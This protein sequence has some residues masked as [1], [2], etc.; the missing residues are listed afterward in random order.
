MVA[1]V[2]TA[3]EQLA[4]RIAAAWTNA[5]LHN[6]VRV[7]GGRRAVGRGRLVS[8]VSGRQ[9]SKVPNGD[10]GVTRPGI[11]A[12]GDGTVVTQAFAAD[13]ALDTAIAASERRAVTAAAIGP[14]T[15]PRNRP[16]AMAWAR[17]TTAASRLAMAA[18]RLPAGPHPVL[19]ER[20]IPVPMPDGVTL[21]ADRYLPASAKHA[22]G[23]GLPPVILVRSPYGRSRF[24][25]LAYGYFFAQHGFQ[26]VVQSVRGTF[27]SGGVFDPL[28]NE[29]GDGLATV[30]WLKT[31][32]WFGGVFAMHGPSYLGYSQWAIAAHAGPELR[33][34]ATQIAASQFYEAAYVG[35]AFALES[36]LSWSDLTSRIERPIGGLTAPVLSVRRAR[37]AAMSGRPLSELDTLAAGEPVP[38][39]QDIL[40]N[41]T[42]DGAYWRL[43][44]HS[45][46]VGRVEAPVSLLGGWYDVFLPWQ[47]QDYA[48]LRRVGRHPRLTIGPWYHVDPRLL[49]AGAEDALA[50]FRAH[51][52]DDPSRLR[53]QPVRLFITGA[54]QWRHYPDWPVPGM[55]QQ[56]WHLH[57][58]HGLGPGRPA[59]SAP[60]AYRFDPADPT[61]AMNGPTLIGN[62]Q[63]EDNRRIEARKDVLTFTS[64][65]LPSG[66]EIIGPVAADLYVRSNRVHTDFVVRLCDVAPTG[67]SVNVC[68]GVRRLIPESPSPDAHGVRRVR[69]D[70]WPAG[71]L[72]LPSHR[73]R[74]QVA[75]GAYPR[76]DLN[77]GTGQ[78]AGGS[79]M[80]A[81]DQEIFHEPDHPSAIILPAAR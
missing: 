17:A 16:A 81:A 27:G 53:E 7:P 51:L 74:V 26:S 71:H 38:F 49:R 1:A 54:E 8:A 33:A 70:L 59:H 3:G 56:R 68:E 32:K 52:L 47:L 2:W 36:T 61:P 67:A 22:T 43:R 64:T 19:V 29:R 42:A 11:A 39:F 31:Q 65:A 9:S 44:D 40:R 66:L 13:D 69:V 18:L 23:A 62:S 6:T 76:V 78:P 73:I 57:E 46:S 58:R 79:S 75:S 72:F 20:D 30:A 45:S 21:F 25:G 34:M 10:A 24:V 28:A 50:W 37:R 35:G 80:V 15:V 60:D 12:S 63:P 14:A 4:R 5:T 48:E 41:A 77:S 55:R